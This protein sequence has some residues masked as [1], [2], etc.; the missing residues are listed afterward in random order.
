MS[1]AEAMTR[2]STTSQ[3]FHIASSLAQLGGVNQHNQNISNQG[4]L[5]QI[6]NL[7]G[8]VNAILAGIK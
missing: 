8:T 7:Q 4:L 6:N 1:T 3:P 5:Q 2:V